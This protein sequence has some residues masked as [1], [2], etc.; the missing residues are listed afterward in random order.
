M[1]THRSFKDL[2]EST[3]QLHVSRVVRAMG[4]LGVKEVSTH[5]DLT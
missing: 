1:I 2:V 5:G 3:T 4:R